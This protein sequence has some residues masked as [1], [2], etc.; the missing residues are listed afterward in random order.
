MISTR[1]RS[2]TESVCTGRSGSSREAVLGGLGAD[3]GGDLGERRRAR[4]ARAST[5]SATVSV[6]KS[7]K[8]WNTIAMPS[9]RAACGLRD[10]DRAALPADLAR[11]RARTTP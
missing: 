5:F 10:L 4:R 8:C 2:P 3:A 11:R 7:E 9:A 6:S 1:C